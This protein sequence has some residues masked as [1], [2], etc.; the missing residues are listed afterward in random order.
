VIVDIHEHRDVIKMAAEQ[1]THRLID[2]NH[3]NWTSDRDPGVLLRQNT[4]GKMVEAGYALASGRNV[5]DILVDGPGV[6]D[7]PGIE[8]KAI[9]PPKTDVCTVSTSS[10]ALYAGSLF[11]IGRPVHGAWAVDL[12][13]TIPSE[14]VRLLPQRPPTD[15]RK[16]TFVTIRLE[17][18]DP[19]QEV[20]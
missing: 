16:S 20:A 19:W 12:V 18:L 9:V 6:P 2:W 1:L 4:A 8:V 17:H 13:G 11:V 14:R 3:T 7:W 5:W 15:G 10:R